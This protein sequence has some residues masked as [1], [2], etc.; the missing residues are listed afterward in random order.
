MFFSILFV[1]SF[2]GIIGTIF[3]LCVMDKEIFTIS[4]ALSVVCVIGMIICF[5]TVSC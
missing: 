4:G 1:L 3:G 5:N 2:I